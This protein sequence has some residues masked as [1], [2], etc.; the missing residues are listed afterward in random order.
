MVLVCDALNDG[1]GRLEVTALGFIPLVRT[2]STS[3]LVRGEPMRYLA[4]F[5]WAPD[6]ILRTP[7]L[8]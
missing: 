2:V 7:A 5:A 6:A 8:R 3:A 4:E 1:I